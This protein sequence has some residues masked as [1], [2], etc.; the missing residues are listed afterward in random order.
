MDSRIEPPTLPARAQL[1][2]APQEREEGKRAALHPRR[3][4]RDHVA[5]EACAELWRADLCVEI[6]VIKTEALVQTVDPLEIVHQAPEEVAAHRNALL[7]RAL[8]LRQIVAQIHD[9]VGVV[10]LPSG[11]T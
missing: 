4:L 6:D 10:D 3:V 7:R 5:K 8:E 1:V 11:P 2:A 9:A